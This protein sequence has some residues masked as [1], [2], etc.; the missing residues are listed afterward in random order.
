MVQRESYTT[1]ISIMLMS[2]DLVTFKEPRFM[3]LSFS[4]HTLSLSLRII[5]AN[6]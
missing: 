3:T 5:G 2:I 4:E 1:L 6:A